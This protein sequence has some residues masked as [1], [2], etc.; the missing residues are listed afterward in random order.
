VRARALLVPVALAGLFAGWATAGTAE[1]SSRCGQESSP[2]DQQ[3]YALDDWLL[4]EGEAV[5]GSWIQIKSF[6][7]DVPGWASGDFVA[8]ESWATFDEG[9]HWVAAGQYAGDYWDENTLHFFWAFQNHEGYTEEDLAAGP[10]PDTWNTYVMQYANKPDTWNVFINGWNVG[11]ASGLG[12][13]SN[14]LQAGL[15]MTNT[16]IKNS[17]ET[18]DAKSYAHGVWSHDWSAGG[19]F[20]EPESEGPGGV[21]AP[22]CVDELPGAVHGDIYFGAQPCGKNGGTEPGKPVAAKQASASEQS[23]SASRSSASTREL[24]AGQIHELALLWSGREGDPH[25][26][27]VS[28]VPA[29]HG[30]TLASAL[31]G[32][33][34]PSNAV[35]ADAGWLD[36]ESVVVEIRGHFH[37]D[38]RVPP[39]EPEPVGTDLSLVIDAHT[40]A[41]IARHLGF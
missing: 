41:V 7:S 5:A 11:E 40:G 17:G 19:T 22:N 35:T 30:Q 33:Y 2:H 3:C 38:A 10:E 8:N 24:T 20:A 39:G 31:T 6:P 29:R 16:N 14:N 26:S 36:G 34:Q 15:V 9:K 12:T 25:P 37:A 18:T 32:A 13:T 1:A 21:A 4:A 28:I 23:P 27:H